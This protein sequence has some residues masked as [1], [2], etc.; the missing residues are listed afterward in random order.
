MKQL[1]SIPVSGNLIYERTSEIPHEMR[2]VRVCFEASHE[3]LEWIREN[4]DDVRLQD[5]RHYFPIIFPWCK[6][7]FTQIQESDEPWEYEFSILTSILTTLSMVKEVVKAPGYMALCTRM[8]FATIPYPD[9]NDAPL[10]VSIFFRHWNG[11]AKKMGSEPFDEEYVKAINSHFATMECLRALNEV[12]KQK[13]INLCYLRNLICAFRDIHSAQRDP[14]GFL[15]YG[16][17]QVLV[18]LLARLA[19]GRRK[20]FHY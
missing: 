18:Y 1:R 17:V 19:S 9:G 3:C 11:I 15:S 2:F 5:F 16:G 8:L 14:E 12:T 13:D 4:N 6:L 7:L 20:F 10:I